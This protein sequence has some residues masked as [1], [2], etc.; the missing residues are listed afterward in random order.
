MN[1]QKN[2]L[3]SSFI[4]TVLIF[5]IG[6]LINHG[7]DAFRISTIED[8]MGQHEI[9]REAYTVESLFAE[10]FGGEECD[11]MTSRISVLKEEI[12]KVGE[13]LGTYSRF[14]FFRRK[15][16]DYLKRKYFLLEFR[17]LTLIETL[18][19][20]C[21]QPYLPIVFFY[22]IDDDASERQGYILQELSKEYD[23]Q[24]IVLTLDKDYEDEP[25]VDLFAE[26]YNVTHAPTIIVANEKYEG[27]VYEGSLNASIRKNLRR[28]DP[29]A[30]EIN[31]D[32][33]PEAAGI[34]KDSIIA[35]LEQVASNE[36]QNPFA[37]GDANLIIGRL[38]GDDERICQ[39]L[40]YY[41]AIKSKNHEEM[42]L[43]YETSAAIGCGRNRA[44]FL[45]AA[46]DEWKKVGNAYRAE[47]L[48]KLASGERL[49]LSFDETALE[50]NETV[51]TG[52]KTAIL[53]A[54]E[55]TNASV[56]TIGESAVTL[57]A[58]SVVVSQDDRVYRDWL[59]GQINNPYGPELLVTFSERLSYNESEL[60]P[61][62]GWHEGGRIKELKKVNLTL[63]V[64]VGTLVARKDGRWFA[65]DD[66]GV[67]RFEVPIDKISYPTTRFLRKDLAVII[68]THGVNM[69]VEQALRDNATA[70]I[71]CCDH[72]GKI[73]A[74]QYLSERNVS[75]ICYP[76][77]YDY[78]ALGHNLSMVGS[79][80]QKVGEKAVIGGRPMNIT[81]DDV[82]VAVNASDTAYALWYYQTPASYFS[83]ITQ[84]MPLNVTYVS[85]D[86]FG[87]MSKVT[88][89]ART[90]NATILAARV[91]NSDDY[92]EVKR[93]LDEDE[94]R[95]IILFHSAPYP[96]GQKIFDEY[97]T[98]SSFDDPNPVFVS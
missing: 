12:K 8:V 4:L 92:D 69:L 44:A 33:T 36:S 27:L 19:E 77:K 7:L 21:G 52:Y 2:V 97:P 49:K 26:Y 72:P 51:I 82:I 31:F 55:K 17:F 91:F 57:D 9:D 83:A 61:E 86:D 73:Y 3:W 18:N 42:A 89:V 32:L 63:K 22:E 38:T 1:K 98:R 13:D 28:T 64:A 84:A 53:P 78:L 5:A 25:L 60:L 47:V 96:Y 56:M 87:E 14:S 23:Q 54:L 39:S 6:I 11:V 62:I 41:D 58:S 65:V 85:L 29:Y 76:D 35:E 88:A 94:K 43:V 67:F 15:D 37:R 45:R 16:Y 66:A 50:A 93:W 90:I 20:R 40:Q 70:V 59:S 10:A 46:A 48:E 81:R 34:S 30:G 24:V 74:A 95:K 71:A 75:V 79:P 68:D 80:P